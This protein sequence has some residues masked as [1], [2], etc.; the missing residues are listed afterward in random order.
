MLDKLYEGAIIE[1]VPKKKGE[2][3]SPKNSLA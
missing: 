2:Q 3:S 1:P